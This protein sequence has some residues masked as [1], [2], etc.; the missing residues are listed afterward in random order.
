MRQFIAIVAAIN[1][2]IPMHQVAHMYRLAYDARLKGVTVTSFL[3]V[4]ER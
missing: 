4:A 3:Q 2:N 1:G